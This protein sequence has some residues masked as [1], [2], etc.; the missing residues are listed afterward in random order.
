MERQTRQ[1]TNLRTK[2]SNNSIKSRYR[3]FRLFA[4]P[5]I[6]L[7]LL[8]SVP[9][10]SSSPSAICDLSI[11]AN[12]LLNSCEKI[13]MPSSPTALELSRED[14]EDAPSTPNLP[15]SYNGQNSLFLFSSKHPIPSYYSLDLST[16]ENYSVANKQFCGPFREIRASLDYDYHGE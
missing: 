9:F 5:A 3:I 14:R 10:I 16:Q 6:A 2:G 11:I 12:L 8:D 13:T 15:A 1:S 7:V 4:V